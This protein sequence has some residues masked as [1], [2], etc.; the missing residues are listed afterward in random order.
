MKTGQPTRPEAPPT[1]ESLFDQPAVSEAPQPAQPS[2]EQIPESQP[3]SRVAEGAILESLVS[4]G[5]VNFDG[6]VGDNTTTSALVAEDRRRHFKRDVYV[7]IRD[8]EQQL[9]FLGRVV[10]GPFHAPHEIGPDTAITRTT[11]LHPDRTRFRPT[12]YVHGSIEVMGQLESG[13]RL[14]PTPTRPRPYSEIYIFPSH[15]LQSLLGIEGN[16]HIGELM[17][18]VGVPVKADVDNKN[19]LPRNVGVFGTVGSG[20]SNTTQVLMEEAVD[21]GWAVVAID[22]EGEYVRMDEP[23]DRR[24]LNDILQTRYGL[25]PGGV[26]DFRV[27]VPASG[28]SEAAD[29]SRFKVPIAAFQPEVMAEILEFSE[30]QIRMFGALTEAAKKAGGRKPKRMGALSGRGEPEAESR[31]YN[32]QDLIDGLGETDDGATTLLGKLRDAEKS[33]AGALRSKLIGLGRTQM[34]DWGATQKTNELPVMDLLVGGRLSVLDVSETGD[35]ERN[36]AIA[37]TLQAL[38][39]QVIET[40]VGEKMPNG[41]RR[42]KVLV[43]IE[44]VH[45]FV[46]RASVGRMRAVLDNLQIIT[47]RGRK[48]WMALSL[49][50]QQPGHVPD[51]LFELANTRFIHQLKSAVNLAPVKA[52][53]GG[54]HEALWSTAV[55]WSGS[56]PSYRGHVQESPFRERATGQ[57]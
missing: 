3:D 23:N 24:D 52:T 56:M 40:A 51:E 14:V 43:V 31:L 34:M 44:E 22:V 11:V 46:S 9:E 18:Y 57:V 42:P 39:D 28:H 1:E 33:T 26:G 54:V 55:T 35:R 2:P 32:L 48:R 30:P 37:Y 21:A 41:Q 50:S 15:R 36:L 6:N 27:Y 49:V 29:P 5:F 12:Y 13:D 8:H 53:T 16:Y 10:E 38:F 20:K 4:L 7:G 45:T 17:G 19:F 25:T 47:R